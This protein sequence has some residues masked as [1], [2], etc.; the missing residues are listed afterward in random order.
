M[1]DTI[2]GFVTGSARARGI[3]V[4]GTAVSGTAPST[5]EEI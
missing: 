3:P 4:P 1:F 2:R 5:D